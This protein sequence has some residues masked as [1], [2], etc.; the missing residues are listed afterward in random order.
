MENVVVNGDLNSKLVD[1]GTA[2]PVQ[3]DNFYTEAQISFISK[4]RSNQ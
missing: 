3:M 4:L 1:F 2:K